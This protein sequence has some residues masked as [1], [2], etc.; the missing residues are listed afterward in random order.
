MGWRRAQ[1]RFPSHL[2]MEVGVRAFTYYYCYETLETDH[3]E[4]DD[5]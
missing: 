4:I 5:I 1:R 2:D 3:D